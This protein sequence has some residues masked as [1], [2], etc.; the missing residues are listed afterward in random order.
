MKS[1]RSCLLPRLILATLSL[2]APALAHHTPAGMEEVDEFGDESFMTALQHPLTGWDHLFAAIAVGLIA[3]AW[4]QRLGGRSVFAFVIALAVGMIAG[5]A[6]MQ[7]PFLEQGLAASLL[8]LAAVLAGPKWL[9]EHA[10]L[11]MACLVGFWHGAAHG[12]EMPRLANGPLYGLGLCLGTGA[13]AALSYSLSWLAP[14]KRSTFARFA[15]G[16]VAAVGAW[17]LVSSLN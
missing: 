2:T 12:F 7:L 16:G 4:G 6:G 13:I 3:F 9:S 15:G 1:S 14:Q 17:M 8:M 5:R 10:I 11:E